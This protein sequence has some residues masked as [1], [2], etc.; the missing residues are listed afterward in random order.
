MVPG[1]LSTG[2]PGEGMLENTT[3]QDQ[4]RR[5]LRHLALSVS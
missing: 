4:V 5:F 2:S 1:M 3:D